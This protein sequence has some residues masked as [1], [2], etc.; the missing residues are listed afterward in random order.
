VNEWLT[1]SGE[2]MQVDFVWYEPQLVVETD[3]FRTHG[4]RHAFR[5][6]RSRDRLLSLA[7]WRVVRYTWHEITEEPENVAEQVRRLLK[8]RREPSFAA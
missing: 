6:D 1:I 3:G 2:E 5:R 7:G 8:P 4:T